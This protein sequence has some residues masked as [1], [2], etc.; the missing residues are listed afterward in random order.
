VRA[1]LAGSA[2]ALMGSG[3]AAE[4]LLLLDPTR[5]DAAVAA[6][7]AGPDGRAVR[8]RAVAAACV[9]DGVLGPA[10]FL[11]RLDRC[12]AEAAVPGL[13]EAV[14]DLPVT[15]ADPGMTVSTLVAAGSTAQSAEVRVTTAAALP[16]IESFDLDRAAIARGDSL[17]ARWQAPGATRC[18]LRD[19]KQA[20]S[21]RLDQAGAL[22][23]APAETTAYTLSCR[24]AFGDDRATLSVTVDDSGEPLRITSFELSTLAGAPRGFGGALALDEPSLVRASWTACRLAD[25]A[26]RASDVAPN[27]SRIV[28]IENTTALRINCVSRRAEAQAI[29]QAEVLA[30]AVFID[31]FEG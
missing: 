26:G 28:R 8:P 11:P 16:E 22:A 5:L 18:V 4:Y 10:A 3:A 30:E 25:D 29:A 14:A 13:A 9:R 7:G 12:R 21:W 17:F 2:L 27:G 19:D 23:L 24:N 6:R 20:T 1:L 15:G 31:D